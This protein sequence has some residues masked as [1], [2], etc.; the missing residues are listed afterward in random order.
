M[1][2]PLE[3]LEGFVEHWGTAE[4][5]QKTDSQATLQR[6]SMEPTLWSR[7]FLPGSDRIFFPFLISPF[8]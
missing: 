7:R 8:Y 4:S 5:E 2:I 6:Q 3:W 1:E